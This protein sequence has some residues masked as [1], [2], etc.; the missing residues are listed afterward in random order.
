MQINP[1]RYHC[2]I[3]KGGD[4]LA[5]T[6]KGTSDIRINK[7][8]KTKDVGLKMEEL[9]NDL[10]NLSTMNLLRILKEIGV[11][12]EYFTCYMCGDVKKRDDF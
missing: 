8:P 1:R 5:K 7:T 6:I 10:R 9:K 3:K 11:G 4:C 2:K 12:S